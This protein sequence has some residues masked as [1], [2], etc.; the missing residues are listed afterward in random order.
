M[1]F[2]MHARDKMDTLGE[3][4]EL[5]TELN[6]ENEL[7]VPICADGFTHG[8]GNMEPVT[9]GSSFNIDIAHITGWQ[10]I[11]ICYV[12]D[13]RHDYVLVKGRG[14]D[15]GIG[16]GYDED[17][18]NYDSFSSI[19]SMFQAHFTSTEASEEDWDAYD[20]NSS[21]DFFDEVGEEAAALPTGLC[22]PNLVGTMVPLEMRQNVEVILESGQPFFAM[23]ESLD[24][25]EGTARVK[26]IDGSSE[27][28]VSV[29][30]IKVLGGSSKGVS[31]KNEYHMSQMGCSVIRKLTVWQS[32][33]WNV[34]LIPSEEWSDLQ[35]RRRKQQYLISKLREVGMDV[36]GGIVKGV[37]STI[38]GGP[39]KRDE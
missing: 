22:A 25:E 24:E 13:F 1:K 29:R 17:R 27:D 28:R 6:F 14:R 15:E 20:E 18:D 34:V 16:G 33:G 12:N 23:I 7:D 4:S 8:G 2:S 38:F 21:D 35:D 31:D 39:K 19:D 3:I 30:R 36:D 26:Y 9:Q 37:L 10:R 11:A 5:L 32:L